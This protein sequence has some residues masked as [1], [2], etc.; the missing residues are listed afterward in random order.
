[1]LGI[2]DTKYKAY[3][4]FK[5]RILEPSQKSI[6]NKTDI[7]F[8]F[9]EIKTGR[10]ITDLK[11]KIKSNPKNKS[12]LPK[13]FRAVKEDIEIIHIL[14][15]LGINHKTANDL[16]DQYPHKR[17]LQNIDYVKQQNKD[18]IDNLAGYIVKAIK[19]NYH[20][21]DQQSQQNLFELKQQD[22]IEEDTLR[23]ERLQKQYKTLKESEITS[24]LKHQFDD[25]RTQ[26]II[27]FMEHNSYK[28]KTM[29]KD[30]E[31]YYTIEKNTA[32][33]DELIQKNKKKIIALISKINFI[34][35]KLYLIKKY[36]EH[37]LASD[38]EFFCEENGYKVKVSFDK[39]GNTIIQLLG[40]IT[41]K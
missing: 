26:A 33:P 24:N 2:P 17:I 16:L 31:D 3:K 35:L 36:I 7:Y 11:F 40:K 10:K 1:M 20:H 23:E 32:V 13:K 38:L 21:N 9:D 39:G 18:N 30:I 15:D 37:D 34:G 29:R 27:Q 8:S 22:K 25:F 28:L 41:S 12:Q 6:N 14:S 5:Q 19:E 4:N